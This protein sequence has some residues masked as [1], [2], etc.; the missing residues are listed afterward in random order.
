MKD[1]LKWGLILGGA[2]YFLFR[3]QLSAMFGG[4]SAPAPAPSSAAP[5]TTTSAATTAQLI[6]QYATNAKL[7]GRMD[8]DHWNWVYAQ[9]RGAGGPA[10]EDVFPGQAR[11]LL[12]TFDEY[13]AGITRRG[14]SGVRRR[15]SASRA[16][17]Y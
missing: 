13:W 16:W 2:S 11:E 7:P 15:T 1:V 17:G 9:V 14:L 10:I 4:S 8:F 3:Q 5:T 12:M 6:Q